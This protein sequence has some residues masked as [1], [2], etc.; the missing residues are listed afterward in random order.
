M[1]IHDS[2]KLSNSKETKIAFGRMTSRSKMAKDLKHTTHEEKKEEKTKPVKIPVLYLKK[3]NAQSS[4]HLDIAGEPATSRKAKTTTKKLELPKPDKQPS[5]IPRRNISFINK[6]R[7]KD[8]DRVFLQNQNVQRVQIFNS[9]GLTDVDAPVSVTATRPIPTLGIIYG[10]SI[11]SSDVYN[12]Y[13]LGSIEQH[14]DQFRPQESEITN[15]ASSVRN[16]SSK[17]DVS[18]IQ[19]E[20]SNNTVIFRNFFKTTNENVKEWLSSELEKPTRDNETVSGYHSVNSPRNCPD[21]SP[22]SSS[23]EFKADLIR[24]YSMLFKKRREPKKSVSTA[25]ISKKSS[26]ANSAK[27]KST[28][29]TDNREVK[30]KNL[31]PKMNTDIKP[32]KPSN[33]GFYAT[34]KFPSTPN[35]TKRREYGT[36]A[37]AGVPSYVE[38]ASEVLQKTTNFETEGR[39]T[40]S[41]LNGKENLPN[42]SQVLDDV[43]EITDQLDWRLPSSQC[44]TIFK[45]SK[46][47]ETTVSTWHG[48]RD[49]SSDYSAFKYQDNCSYHE[50]FYH[51]CWRKEVVGRDND[52]RNLRDS[53]GRCKKCHKYRNYP[54]KSKI[55]RRLV[56]L[57]NRIALSRV[58]KHRWN[59]VWKK[60]T[61]RFSDWSKST[62]YTKFRMLHYLQRYHF[63]NADVQTTLLVYHETGTDA[64]A[65]A[66]KSAAIT[67]ENFQ[68]A[69]RNELVGSNTSTVPKNNH[70]NVGPSIF[71][72]VVEKQKP[73][74]I[75][76]A[77]STQRS[78][79][80]MEPK[81]RGSELMK[82]SKYI[83]TD[84]T[85][86]KSTSTNLECTLIR[87]VDQ[88]SDTMCMPTS[89][90][91]ALVFNNEIPR[92]IYPPNMMIP[93]HNAATDITFMPTLEAPPINSSN[94]CQCKLPRA[95]NSSNTVGEIKCSP[96]KVPPAYCDCSLSTNTD[97]KN[98][99]SNIG[100][101]MI[102]NTLP[103]S[104]TV[105]IKAESMLPSG[106]SKRNYSVQLI[107][108]KGTDMIINPLPIS[109]TV[110]IK[111]ESMVPSENS[112][113]ID[114]DQLISNK[115]SNLIRATSTSTHSTLKNKSK[116]ESNATKAPPNY[117]SNIKISTGTLTTE[118]SFQ[119]TPSVIT[120]TLI[121]CKRLE[122]RGLAKLRTP[123]GTVLSCAG[124]KITSVSSVNLQTCSVFCKPASTINTAMTTNLVSTRNTQCFTA[125]SLFRRRQRDTSIGLD[126][127]LEEMKHD[128]S[129]STNEI[130]DLKCDIALSTTK[131]IDTASF[132]CGAQLSQRSFN[133]DFRPTTSTVFTNTE[134]EVTE[135]IVL[136]NASVLTD[137]SKYTTETCAQYSSKGKNDSLESE[138]IGRSQLMSVRMLGDS[139]SDMSTQAQ[140]LLIDAET[141][142]I[143]KGITSAAVFTSRF[144]LDR[145]P[146]DSKE[147]AI[148]LGTAEV[149]TD[150]KANKEMPIN[151]QQETSPPKQPVIPSQAE[152]SNL[153]QPRHPSVVI[154]SNLNAA[155]WMKGCTKDDYQ[156]IIDISEVTVSE[157]L[158]KATLAVAT[159]NAFNS[160]LSA[161]P[162]PA[163]NCMSTQ[164]HVI[165]TINLADVLPKNEENT[166]PTNDRQGTNEDE[167]RES[168]LQVRPNTCD[169]GINVKLPLLIERRSATVHTSRHILITPKKCHAETADCLYVYD[170]ARCVVHSQRTD[171]GVQ[172]KSTHS[173]FGQETKV[174]PWQGNRTVGLVTSVLKPH[175]CHKHTSGLLGEVLTPQVYKTLYE[176]SKLIAKDRSLSKEI[177]IVENKAERSVQVLR[178]DWSCVICPYCA[179]RFTAHE[180]GNLDVNNEWLETELATCCRNHSNYLI[181]NITRIKDNFKKHLPMSR[182]ERDFVEACTMKP[183]GRQDKNCQAKFAPE[184]LCQN[185][186]L[187]PTASATDIRGEESHDLRTVYY[188]LAAIEGRVRRLK[189]NL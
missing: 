74:M 63:D 83:E 155:K 107:S 35:P 158:E 124:T 102:I 60:T 1:D 115:V 175:C 32:L 109:P 55:S 127:T 17:S 133:D 42:S 162:E 25:D 66:Q 167:Q 178:D 183:S 43:S 122:N 73:Q 95:N 59:R 160:N 149:K 108:N 8:T 182:P 57:K 78:K 144:E 145:N 70:V 166:Q 186:I 23:K 21:P 143:P 141:R 16:S 159:S 22:H 2:P 104:P 31:L 164:P 38:C 134:L 111:A 170:R 7:A 105:T 92:Q 116:T 67:T 3:N 26:T 172:I 185:C 168:A 169:A 171:M 129:T 123:K 153:V 51:Y 61:Q 184:Y 33:V 131:L 46:E 152:K 91:S 56:K 15:N 112:N 36:S 117:T 139:V 135:P 100:T 120:D 180:I 11:F 163:V 101:D 90:V 165:S 157:S 86:L 39:D 148:D 50:Y 88:C 41:T 64:R 9:P 126:V 14:H 142:T 174:K 85:C 72:M 52:R 176:T 19:K 177:G 12:D 114:S 53:Y 150:I 79:F 27:S 28:K 151:S 146:R 173:G 147:N 24:K 189:Q 161:K 71:P 68:V 187:P 103:I 188:F 76:E 48:Q 62:K 34:F 138:H 113:R 54:V 93:C 6:K 77:I 47:S 20:Q 13:F 140:P 181:K 136:I 132:N 65:L 4:G 80:S 40:P 82:N 106:N 29:L 121:P 96:T 58:C 125:P 37:G 154:S 128:D 49:L 118:S 87:K 69:T 97:L 18:Q 5:R 130:R 99:Y 44:S 45:T 81:L 98:T 119:D 10:N 75:S 179:K 94:I 110:T 30:T 89:T 156:S 84:G 137:R